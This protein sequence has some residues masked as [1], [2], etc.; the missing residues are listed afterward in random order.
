MVA[1]PGLHPV[2]CFSGWFPTANNYL[3]QRPPCRH[4]VLW[5][6]QRTS[7]SE[8]QSWKWPCFTI[9]GSIGLV[10]GFF[11]VGIPQITEV[12][13]AAKV[14]ILPISFV[15]LTPELGQFIGATPLAISFILGPIFVGLLAPFWGIMGS[16]SG[17]MIFMISSPLLHY[18][19]FMPRWKPGVD[20]IQTQISVGVDFWTPFALGITVAVTLI[21]VIQ[22]VRSSREHRADSQGDH[23][24]CG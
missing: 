19:G 10:F 3:F 12:F 4:L 13:T 8:E 23:K 18:F 1:A 11:Y 7:G 6:W 24:G 16:F 20:A 14:S 21:S 15:D 9:G 5:L 2:T 22:M 17:V